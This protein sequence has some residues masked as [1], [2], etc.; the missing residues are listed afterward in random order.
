MKATY[1]DSI[2]LEI[3]YQI[4]RKYSAPKPYTSTPNDL[5]LTTILILLSNFLVY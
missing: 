1:F 3:I 5:I 2:N 4:G